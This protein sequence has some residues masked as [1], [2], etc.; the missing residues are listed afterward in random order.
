MFLGTID[1]GLNHHFTAHGVLHCALP[2]TGKIKG[3]WLW[4]PFSLAWAGRRQAILT[5]ILPTW[6]LLSMKSRAAG[7]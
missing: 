7:S 1:N 3:E 6:L 2:G 5:T 4:E